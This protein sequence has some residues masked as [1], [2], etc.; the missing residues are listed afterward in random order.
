MST[1]EQRDQLFREAEER[2]RQVLTWLADHH[3]HMHS[4]TTTPIGS[5]DA[6]DGWITSADTRITAEVKVRKKTREA[7]I[8][9]NTAKHFKLLELAQATSSLPLL[10]DYCRY[11]GSLL[12]VDLSRSVITHTTKTI[13]HSIY[14]KEVTSN[15]TIYPSTSII[16]VYHP[17]YTFPF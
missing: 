8:Y 13:L 4:L 2:E 3:P 7:P 16:D 10:F 1:K 9:I 6:N 15:I 5:Y 17:A 12:V 14:H 11:D